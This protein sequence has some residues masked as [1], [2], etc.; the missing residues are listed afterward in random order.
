MQ[1]Y[2]VE[3]K[4]ND[5]FILS[6]SDSH[7]VKNVMRFNVGDSVEI[8]YKN[9]LYICDISSLN[10]VVCDVVNKVTESNELNISVTIAQSLVKEQKMDIILQK[11][12]EL[13]INGFIPLSTS[14]SVVK[15][16]KGDKKLDRW[17]KIVKEASEQS[18]RV[19][20]PEIYDVTSINELCNIEGYDL[21][22][23]FTVNEISQNLKKVLT[24]VK[25]CAKI[26]IVVGPEGGFTNEE[27]QK[28]IDNGF[29]STSLGKSVLR[30]ETA[31]LFAMS[32]IRYL[33]MEL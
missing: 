28:L 9:E 29:I 13:G 26:I 12:T 4:E 8:I 6:D 33:D 27:E 16:A 1:R 18:K 14:R 2:F 15:L 25:T 22:L 10:P 31:G 20:I 32:I 24:S 23:L 5:K 11:N 17:R 30:T 19:I 3:Q 7:H 21:K